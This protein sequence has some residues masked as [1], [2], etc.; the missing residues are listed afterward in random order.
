MAAKEIGKVIH[1]FD[2]IN[3]AVLKLSA[4]LKK[5]DVVSVK[6]G[7]KEFEETISSM[8]ID[9]EDVDKGKKGDEVAVKLSNKTKE[10]ATIYSSE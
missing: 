7:E 8:Q 2:K 9:H 3:V 5:G 1:W 10:G 6:R 4:P